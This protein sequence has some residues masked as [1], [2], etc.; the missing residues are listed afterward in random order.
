MN[1]FTNFKFKKSI[2]LSL[3]IIIIDSSRLSKTN[4]LSLYFWIFITILWKSSKFKLALIIEKRTIINIPNI[5]PYAISF[6]IWKFK[7][8]FFSKEFPNWIP[9]CMLITNARNKN[10]EK[11]IYI[12]F[13][14]QKFSKTWKQKIELPKSIGI[15]VYQ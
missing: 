15:A 6:V 13:I 8:S 9:Y 11:I 10:P 14:L 5:V 1:V 12:Q 7:G 2:L 4:L 3:F